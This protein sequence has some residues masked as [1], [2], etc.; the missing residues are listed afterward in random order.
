MQVDGRFFYLDQNHRLFINNLVQDINS[1]FFILIL[2]EL[3]IWK[4]SPRDKKV[5]TSGLEPLTSTMST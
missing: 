3:T 1:L 2:T 5:I 4:I